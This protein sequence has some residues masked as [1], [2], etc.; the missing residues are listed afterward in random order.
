MA[1]IEKRT[2]KDGKTTSYRALVRLKG[3]PSQSATF[4]RLTDARRWV[5]D[6]ESAIREG[7][8]FKTAEAK[9]HTLAEAIDRYVAEV[10]PHR[11]LSAADRTQQLRW[12]KQ[13]IGVKVLA[14][15]N[16]VLISDYRNRLATATLPNGKT[17]S[18]GTVNRYLAA[19]SHLL[20]IAVKEWGWLRENPMASVGKM[21]EPPGRIRFL[22][23]DER[24]RLLEACKT[25][26]SPYLYPLVVLTL[27]TGMRR[28]EALGLR[29]QAID[30]KRKMILIGTT[31]NGQPKGMPLQSLALR[32]I[33]ELHAKRDDSE[34][35]FPNPD[36]SRPLDIRTAWETARKRAG[37]ENFRFHD[38]RHSAASYLAMNGA[39]L[40]EIAD[41]LGHKTLAM[42]KRYAHIGSCPTE[43]WDAGHDA[44]A[45]WDR[46]AMP[47]V[48][49]PFTWRRFSRLSE[50]KPVV[51]AYL[52]LL[53]RFFWLSLNLSSALL[54]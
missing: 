9:R 25:S 22:N 34:F 45:R 15:V 48:T 10:L 52:D 54:C 50:D 41:V 6:T 11:P 18:P 21:K 27:S 24:P 47:P 51:P 13:E 8:H 37:I 17:R 12:W 39:S 43:T 23:D 1:N 35:V 16:S 32:L 33:T 26:D 7:R 5:Q 36:G 42:V 2:S 53:L 30:L 31:K 28:N 20:T 3:H 4:E 29:W 46:S 40:M 44:P 19:L 49:R 38:L 14:D